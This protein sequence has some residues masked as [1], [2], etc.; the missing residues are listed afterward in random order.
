ML[1]IHYVRLLILRPWL[2]EEI[3]SASPSSLG[4]NILQEIRSLCILT[5]QQTIDIIY[6]AELNRPQNSSWHAVYCKKCVDKLLFSISLKPTVLHTAAS[7]LLAAALHPKSS[8]GIDLVFEPYQ[9]SW[10]KAIETLM[11][12]KVQLQASLHAVK[13]LES[14]RE[15]LR[16][17]TIDRTPEGIVS[18]FLIQCVL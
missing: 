8:G 17:I 12:N 3:Q 2:L 13:T 11:N 9:T 7:I 15:K 16:D 4:R 5:A 14:C 6:E 1:R 18:F 10:Q